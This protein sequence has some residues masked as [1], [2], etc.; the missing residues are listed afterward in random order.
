MAGRA[1]SIDIVVVLLLKRMLLR[2]V[3]GLVA[4]TLHVVHLQK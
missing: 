2:R 4:I 3:V 1:K